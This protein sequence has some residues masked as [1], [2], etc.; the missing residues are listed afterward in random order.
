MMD[1]DFTRFDTP[2]GTITDN[3]FMVP[4]SVIDEWASQMTTYELAIYML[5]LRRYNIAWGHSSYESH[6]SMASRLG[7]SEPTVREGLH[8]LEQPQRGAFQWPRHR[9]NAA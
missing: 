6:K 2:N 8:R 1:T 5:I 7:M 4:N 3:F 9:R